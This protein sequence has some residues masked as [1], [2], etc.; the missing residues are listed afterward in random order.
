MAVINVVNCPGKWY[1]KYWCKG[2][3]KIISSHSADDG[4]CKAR[5]RRRNCQVSSDLIMM[6]NQS[7]MRVNK[8]ETNKKMFL[9]QQKVKYQ[10]KLIYF[11]S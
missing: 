4:E 9:F 2:G 8:Q 10:H 7:M 11:L 6:T 3:K 5:R 1:E